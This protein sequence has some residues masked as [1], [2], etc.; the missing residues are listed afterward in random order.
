MVSQTLMMKTNSSSM[1]YRYYR[2]CFCCSHARSTEN[3]DLADSKRINAELRR[4]QFINCLS[5]PGNI[6]DE[7]CDFFPISEYVLLGSFL[8]IYGRSGTLVSIPYYY[9]YTAHICVTGLGL[10][11][12]VWCVLTCKLL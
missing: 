2:C 8:S 12:H 9:V 6:N 10:A 5:W 3:V 11:C 7:Y 1:N 4:R